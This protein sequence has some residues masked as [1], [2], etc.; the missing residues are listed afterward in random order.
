MIDIKKTSYSGLY[1]LP[2]ILLAIFICTSLLAVSAQSLD[3]AVSSHKLYESPGRLPIVAIIDVNLI[4]VTGKKLVPHQTV[5]IKNGRISA[6]ANT[7]KIIVPTDALKINGKGQYLLPG[8]VD[9]HVHFPKDSIDFPITLQ[10][11]LSN[12]ITTIVNMNGSSDLLRLRENVFKGQIQGPTIFTTGPFINRPIVKTADEVE[13]EVIAEKKEGYD[14]LKIH[15]ELS[16]EQFDRLFKIADKEKIRAV[17][18]VPGNLGIQAALAAHQSLIVHAEEFLYTYFM[19]NRTLP[20]DADEIDSTV[21]IIARQTK[22][23]GVWV[24]PTLT[25]FDQI[26]AQVDSIDAVLSRPEMQYISPRIYNDWRPENNT[27]IKRWQKSDVLRFSAQYRVMEKLVNGLHKAGVPLLVGTDCMSSAVIPG[28]SFH[29]EM[30][31]FAD[32]GINPFEIIKAA[33]LNAAVFL[34]ISDQT[35]SIEVNKMADL[36]LVKANPLKNIGNL[37]L[38]SGIILKGEWIPESKLQQDLM[39]LSKHFQRN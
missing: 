28:F 14:F 34:R 1:V 29:D 32:A 20:T 18:H 25:V 38:R 8:L 19:F 24:S 11:F 21:K 10:L 12:G 16:A 4:P 2:A 7:N 23:A 33:T 22:R 35:G 13:T 6:I 27:Y 3:R 30:A 15:G 5:L 37:K 26:I 31:R 17:G 39:N 9:F 36:L